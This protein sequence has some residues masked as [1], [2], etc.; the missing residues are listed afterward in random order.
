MP[1]LPE[2]ETIVRELRKLVLDRSIS[3]ARLFRED[4]LKNSTLRADEFAGF[5]RHRSFKSIERHGK[6]ILFSLDNGN[7]ML[8]H[9][10]MTCK[11]VV[12]AGDAPQEKHLCSQFI[13]TDGGSM[14]HIDVRRFGRLECYQDGERIPLLGRLGVDPLSEEFHADSLKPIAF[15]KDGKTPRNY[16]TD[17]SFNRHPFPEKR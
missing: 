5:F 7:R 16:S 15:G 8:A 6:F 9:L 11:F 13:F 14:D 3:E 10:G 1:E 4:I 2:V 12:S 17:S